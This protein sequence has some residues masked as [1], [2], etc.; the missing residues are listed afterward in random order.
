MTDGVA[1]END[2]DT[3]AAPAQLSEYP[4]EFS[5]TGGEFF[6]IWIVNIALSVITLGIY[7]AWATV[8]TRRYFY[9]KTTLDGTPFQFTA[10]AI[11]ILIGRIIAFAIFGFYSYLSTFNPGY[12]IG[13]LIFVILPLTPWMIMK[14]QKFRA[15]YSSWRNIPFR[16]TGTYGDA[17]VTYVLIPVGM[18]FTLYI[19][20]P[21][22]WKESAKYQF[23]NL[24]YGKQQFAFDKD[25]KGFWSTFWYAVLIFFGFVL[26]ITGLT[27]L[28]SSV[29]KG[30]QLPETL[31]GPGVVIFVLLIYLPFFLIAF[32]V[33]SRLF[34]A[35]LGGVS[36]GPG[37]FAANMPT[38]GWMWLQI[39]NILMLVFTLGIAYPWVKVRTLRYKIRHLSVLANAALLFEAAGDEDDVGAMGAELASDFDFDISLF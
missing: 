15:R 20:L 35:V 32:F 37:Q 30:T 1:L 10:R 24:Y 18:V 13:F 28:L 26:L 38:W 17:L 29:F 14:S 25:R 27:V 6:R 7:S 39:T 33:Q 5:G 23:N 12:A 2:A 8:R 16:F 31:A 3:E 22:F 21:L 19:I 36:F 9:G 11:P 34:N 4:L